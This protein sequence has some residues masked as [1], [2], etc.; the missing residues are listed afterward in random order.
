MKERN[1]E[2]VEMDKRGQ[3]TS[4]VEFS[5]INGDSDYG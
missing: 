2:H 3:W 4:E 1:T 5:E